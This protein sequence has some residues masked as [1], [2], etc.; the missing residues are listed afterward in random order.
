MKEPSLQITTILSLVIH[1]TFLILA[2]VIIKQ[3]NHFVMPS[4][5]IV[6]LVSPESEADISEKEGTVTHKGDSVPPMSLP[7]ETSKPR[8]NFKDTEQYIS[9]IIAA[10]KAKR[11][12]EEIV[13]LR[14]IISLKSSGTSEEATGIPQPPEGEGEATIL[15]SYYATIRGEIWR[16]WAFPETRDENLEA[17]ISITIMRDGTIKINKIEKSSGNLLFDRSVLKA[18]NKASPVSPPPYEMEIG[19]RFTP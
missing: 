10:I 6:S 13:R 14:N 15:N 19:V 5:Y 12:A 1:I 7:S 17:I 16:H 4:P 11:K 18:I 8:K 3:T 2:L 9:D